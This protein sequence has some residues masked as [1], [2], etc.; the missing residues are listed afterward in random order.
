MSKSAGKANDIFF[1][2]SAGHAIAHGENPYS[3]IQSPDVLI[4]KKYSTYLPGFYLIVS[5]YVALGHE[6]FEEWLSFWR[7]SS[8]AIHF[9]IGVFLFFVL[10]P[11]GGVWL[12]LFGSQFWLLS[13]WTV[14]IMNSGQIDAVAIAILLVSIW[15]LPRCKRTALILFGASLSIKQIGIF[16]LPV[17]LLLESDLHKPFMWNLGQ[18]VKNLLYMAAFPLLTCL[19]FIIWD[20]RGMV[21]SILFSATRFPVGL[22]FPSIDAL[23][24]YVGLV[25]KIPMILM[26]AF[27]Y[28]LVLQRR[29]GRFTAALVLF[30]TFISFNSVLYTQYLPWFCAFLGL[31]IA[32]AKPTPAL[33]SQE[34]SESPGEN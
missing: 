3:K 23:L 24:G 34:H 20:A 1:I 5:A 31:A 13:R 6:T 25:A 19:P 7:L 10:L 12:A 15:I 4:N 27:V 21:W 33:A 28:F 22:K 11:R 16:M 14:Q 18:G 17:Y 8:F 32:E 29:I 30:L 2:W 26:M 9:A